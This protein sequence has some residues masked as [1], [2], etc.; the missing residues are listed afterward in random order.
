MTNQANLAIYQQRVA[1]HEAGHAAGIHFNNS[2]RN[3]PPVFYKIIFKDIN[4]SSENDQPNCIARV[5]GGRLIQSLPLSY[6][7]SVCQ[8]SA[9]SDKKLFHF[10]DEYRSAFEADI[11]NLLI[12]PLAEAKY[13]AHVDGEPFNHQLVTVEALKNYG[14]NEDLALVNDYLQSYST[15]KDVQSAS[16]NWFFVLAYN[17]V[18]DTANWKVI[19]Q[20]ANYILASNKNMISCEEV[21]AVFESSTEIGSSTLKSRETVCY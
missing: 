6:D 16:L 7:D 4:E 13:I 20:L 17:F 5:K 14:G 1:Y 10:S 8:S 12:G 21:A 18:N 11:V 9:C 3:L 19:S 2:L 15:D